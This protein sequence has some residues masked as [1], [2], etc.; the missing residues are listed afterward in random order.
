MFL[1]IFTE[2]IKVKFR[3]GIGQFDA[4]FGSQTFGKAKVILFKPVLC[5]FFS[6]GLAC[7]G[8]EKEGQI[9]GRARDS[10]M[11]PICQ[12]GANVNIAGCFGVSLAFV[13]HLV[14]IASKVIT[15]YVFN[16]APAR[17]RSS[18]MIEQHIPLIK[19]SVGQAF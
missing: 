1:E 5:I 6:H 8:E 15:D 3:V 17:T 2:N 16:R 13:L 14:V 10:R 12:K 4:K 19:L 18:H 11:F 7:G 9:G